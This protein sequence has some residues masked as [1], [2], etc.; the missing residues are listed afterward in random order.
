MVRTERMNASVRLAFCML[1]LMGSL[2][3]LVTVWA[4]YNRLGE[5]KIELKEEEEKLA[6]VETTKAER[7]RE[8]DLL[9]NNSDYREIRARDLENRSKPGEYIFR[10]ER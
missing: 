2:A 3:F 8:L 4:P 1:V 10:I 7:E 5:S 6:R 9:R